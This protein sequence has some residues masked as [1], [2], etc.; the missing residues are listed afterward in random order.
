M[1]GDRLPG[2]VALGEVVALEQPRHRIARREPDH[3]FRAE[4]V[5]P[6]GVEQDLR[7]L[8]VE[9]LEGLLAVAARV[10]QD[11][12]A[13]QRR[14]R[15]V[16]AGRVAD[17][18]GEVADQELHLVAELLEVA[19]LVDHHRVPEVQVGGGGIQ[20]QLDAQRRAARELFRELALDDQL[21]GAALDQRERFLDR[22]AADF[23]H[24]GSLLD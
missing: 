6:L 17:H 1:H 4:L 20:P 15:L 2:A 14:A 8:R 22:H 19:Q 5:R 24:P 21:L 10:L 23:R 13:R 18:P 9:D 12:L 16:L 7:A 3:A 11:L